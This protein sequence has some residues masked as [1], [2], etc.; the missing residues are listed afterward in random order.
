MNFNI[1]AIVMDLI[2]L[3]LDFSILCLPISMIP[4]LKLPLKYRISLSVIVLL[5]G[6]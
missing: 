5:G 6:L 3:L 4:G 1:F 2:D